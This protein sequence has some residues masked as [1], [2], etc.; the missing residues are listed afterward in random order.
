MALLDNIPGWKVFSTG[1]GI[2]AL[3]V[4][5][6]FVYAWFFAT[7]DD[8]KELEEKA[9]H[10]AIEEVA[11]IYSDKVQKHGQQRVIVM[12]V[13]GDTT[14]EQ[15]REMLIAR[16]N[17]FEDDAVQA[18][19]PDSPSLEERAIS[20]FNKVA[21]DEESERDPAKVF[22]DAGEVDEVLSIDVVKKWAGRDSGVCKLDVTRIVKEDDTEERKAAVLDTVRYTGLSG[23]ALDTGEEDVEEGPGFLSG[24]GRY[25]LGLLIVLV[26]TAVLPF[27]SW[28]LAKAAFK[29]D[30]NAA[31]GALLVG[32][33]VVDIAAL[34]GVSWWLAESTFNTAA[35]ISAGL[36]LP[37]AL[38]WNL[39]LLNFIEEQ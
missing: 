11:K 16:L 13:S 37:V 9:V 38:V 10:N 1:I 20:I 39:R 7:P 28:P 8:L 14:N 3:V 21:K 31:N 18:K 4:V 12:P 27:L 19:K 26:A 34:F 32:L 25:M 2:A 23:T 5:G 6:Y 33:T 35:V 30:S 29:A 15:I 36:L 22:E 17:G 24:F